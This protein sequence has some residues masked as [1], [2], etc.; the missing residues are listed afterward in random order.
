MFE[1]WA[2]ALLSCFHLLF[3][4]SLSSCT[5]PI[6]W[7]D[8]I[9]AVFRKRGLLLLLTTFLHYPL[10]LICFSWT[11][12][13]ILRSFKP[14]ASNKD[15]LLQTHAIHDGTLTRLSLDSLCSSYSS[16]LVLIHLHAINLNHWLP[17][18]A[19]RLLA[20]TLRLQSCEIQLL[21]APLAIYLCSEA[22]I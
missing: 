1:P 10:A 3:L 6:V 18:V 4:L 13:Y 20:V 11:L 14:L 9:K 7:T 5:C 2:N 8:A 21:L 22:P 19:Q 16:W 12:G 17:F 15:G